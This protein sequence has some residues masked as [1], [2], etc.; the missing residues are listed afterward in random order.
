MSLRIIPGYS[1]ITRVQSAKGGTT[2]TTANTATVTFGATPTP[3]N[4]IVI[5]GGWKNNQVPLALATNITFLNLHPLTNYNATAVMY[6]F[7]M[8]G[9]VGNS[10]GSVITVNPNTGN[11]AY[12]LIGI[13]YSGN[14]RLGVPDGWG[15]NSGSSAAPNS[16][17]MTTVD[18]VELCVAS[19]CHRGTWA[20]EQTTLYATPTNS[21]TIVD[22]T[23]TNINT[24]NNDI[25][26]CALERITT[27][28]ISASGGA[29]ITSAQWSGCGITLRNLSQF[30][31]PPF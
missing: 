13:E 11:V 8:V 15:A 6:S 10:P 5:A 25:A 24:S 17:T 27:A 31:V 20:T 30:G 16:G 19:L 4:I 29:A 9:Y 7:I 3:G 2:T 21:F 18:A 14:P 26:V 22:Q 23:S 1:A 28:T 12:R